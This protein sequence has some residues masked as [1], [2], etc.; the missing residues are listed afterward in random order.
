MQAEGH[1]L[2]AARRRTIHAME[3]KARNAKGVGEP[4]RVRVVR[5]GAC[6]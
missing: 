3:H 4:V 5:E 2:V 6:G 1:A